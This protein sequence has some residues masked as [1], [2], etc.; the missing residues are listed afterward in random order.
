MLPPFHPSLLLT[1]AH[2]KRSS[3]GW[4]CTNSLDTRPLYHEADIQKQ[5]QRLTP[6]YI[7]VSDSSLDF[8]MTWEHLRAA[9]GGVF[10]RVTED[11]FHSLRND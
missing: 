6:A 11:I 7:L 1:A 3:A 8:G 2:P 10:F 4:R 9:A 5:S